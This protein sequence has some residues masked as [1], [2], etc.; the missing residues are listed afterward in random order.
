M[1]HLQ[2]AI[3]QTIKNNDIQGFQAFLSEEGAFSKDFMGKNA[4]DYAATLNHTDI[5]Q[6]LFAY[7][8]EQLNSPETPQDQ[9]QALLN[10][11]LLAAVALNQK[12]QIA[13]LVTQG[14]QLQSQGRVC[15]LGMVMQNQHLASTDRHALIAYLFKL[16]ANA[17]SPG[18]H[19][20]PFFDAILQ[21]DM[22]LIALFIA[23]GDSIHEL[24]SKTQR[25]VLMTA[26]QAKC[27][28]ILQW[29]LAFNPDV[30]AVTKHKISALS[31]AILAQNAEAI[32]ALLERGAKIHPFAPET[33]L[34]IYQ[35]PMF[36]AVATPNIELLRQFVYLGAPIHIEAENKT[37]LLYA[38]QKN[39]L[40][41]ARLLIEAGADINQRTQYYDNTA[42]K[43]ALE[44]KN[45]DFIYELLVAGAQLIPHS[46]ERRGIA[47]LAAS[48]NHQ[49]LLDLLHDLGS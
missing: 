25:T 15:V 28:E 9:Q 39:H 48:K 37:L 47:K 45:V 16:G 42:L 11:A 6:R 29:A 40:A 46:S 44:L 26:I 43:A 8:Q 1:N 20:P 21:K 10:E 19:Q 35:T 23:A 13:N 38:I 36:M 12:N 30:N 2:P 31:E 33:I 22:A 24:K 17:N 41:H 3:F 14:A 5:I 7:Y 32:E 27:P 49:P 34:P 4:L 18:M